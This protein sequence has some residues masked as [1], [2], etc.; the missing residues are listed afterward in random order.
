MQNAY[1]KFSTEKNLRSQTALDKFIN[2]A[3]QNI[4]SLEL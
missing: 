1:R 4:S 3:D 2:V